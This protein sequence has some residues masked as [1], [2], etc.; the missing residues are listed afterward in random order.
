MAAT[1]LAAS[2]LVREMPSELSRRPTSVRMRLAG[3]AP[4]SIFLLL[5]QV[6]CGLCLAQVPT[7]VACATLAAGGELGIDMASVCADD[8][9]QAAAEDDDEA[10]ENSALVLLQP[11]RPRILREKVAVGA[12]APS[13]AMKHKV[14]WPSWADGQRLEIKGMDGPTVTKVVIVTAVAAVLWVALAVCALRHICCPSKGQGGSVPLRIALLVAILAGLVTTGILLLHF[15][16]GAVLQSCIS[17]FDTSFLGTT[18]EIDHLDLHPFRGLLTING[19]TVRN[20]QGYRSEYLLRADRVLIDLDT[21]PLMLS[22]GHSI[23]VNSLSLQGASIFYEQALTTSNVEDVV[24]TLRRHLQLSAIAPTI[25]GRTI[26]LHK[27]DVQGVQARA[28][29][30]F[31]LS[32]GLTIWLAD[33]HFADFEK[34]TGSNTVEAAILVLYET[35]LKSVLKAFKP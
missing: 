23:N 5:M 10:A 2:A 25:Q 14:V 17:S 20:P 28:A 6:G 35:L 31:A 7:A 32:L 29:A 18:V 12:Q 16:A 34:E 21:L 24:N 15:C 13:L 9:D 19:L 1:P 8:L 30:S 27:V 22:L 4:S 33:L 11:V 3:R 26:L